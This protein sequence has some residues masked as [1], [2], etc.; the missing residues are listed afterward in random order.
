[1]E[2][3]LII[4]C[5][6]A[7]I[8]GLGALA[9]MRNSR[10]SLG[11]A[12]KANEYANLANEHANL[13]NEHANL[14]NRHAQNANCIQAKE[15]TDQYF[16]NVKIWADEVCDCIASAI[17]LD[18]LDTDDKIDTLSIDGATYVEGVF[19]LP[20]P[21]TYWYGIAYKNG[22]IY[23]TDMWSG[24]VHNQI[25]VMDVELSDGTSWYKIHTYQD[26]QS[27]PNFGDT[28]HGIDFHGNDLVVIQSSYKIFHRLEFELVTGELRERSEK[29]SS[30]ESKALGYVLKH[31]TKDDKYTAKE[32]MS[33][34]P[35]P[36]NL[37]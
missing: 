21:Q 23:L 17:H 11:Q 15:W 9:S 32:M 35:Q 7:V 6:A 2:T 10:K 18:E 14:A 26:A 5:A 3:S 37:Y 8:S 4:S 1:M 29:F 27:K 19:D 13:A 16:N 33:Q 36:K 30:E 31:G 22:N 25:H 24:T 12:E 34:I 20:T 28:I